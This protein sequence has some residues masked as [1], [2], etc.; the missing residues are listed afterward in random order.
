MRWSL[1]GVCVLIA[2]L[3]IAIGI[4]KA[5][6]PEIQVAKSSRNEFKF[7]VVMPKQEQPINSAEAKTDTELREFHESTRQAFS[8]AM[9]S[10]RHRGG[11]RV[12]IGDGAVKFI[13][14]SIQ[15]DVT[16]DQSPNQNTDNRY[17]IWGKLGHHSSTQGSNTTVTKQ[18]PFGFAYLAPSTANPSFPYELLDI[19]LVSADSQ[20]VFLFNEMP[21]HESVRTSNPPSRELNAIEAKSFATLVAGE[22]VVISN[23]DTE[24]RM[25]GSLRNEQQCA[26]CHEKEQSSLLG[27]LSYRFQLK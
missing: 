23:S 7:D 9:G 5:Q 1:F 19:Q 8:T 20:R 16:D 10:G 27:A 22:D 26:V 2:S 18:Y 12:L 3:G 15:R 14:D 17:G 6:R 13:T 21:T 11:A 25:L 24:T 4:F